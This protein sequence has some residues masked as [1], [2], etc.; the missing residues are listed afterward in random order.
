MSEERTTINNVTVVEKEAKIKEWLKAHKKEISIAVGAAGITSFVFVKFGCRTLPKNPYFGVRFEAGIDR[1]SFWEDN[2]EGRKKFMSG[3]MFMDLK[4]LK[5]SDL[6]NA[7][8][9]L[10]QMFPGLKDDTPLR[11]VSMD[12]NFKV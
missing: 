3:H 4:D 1:N 12:Y 8:K 11:R 6:G 5:V 10:Q 2:E 7:G 9:K